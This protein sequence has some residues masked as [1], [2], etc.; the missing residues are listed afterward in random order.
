MQVHEK[1][2]TDRCRQQQRGTR[3]M[4]ACL[5]GPDVEC[6]FRNLN[7]VS[8]GLN[9]QYRIPD[10]STRIQELIGQGEDFRTYQRGPRSVLVR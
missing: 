3:A 7:I 5:M 9:R 10:E 6:Q 2:K 4:G 8:A 1:A